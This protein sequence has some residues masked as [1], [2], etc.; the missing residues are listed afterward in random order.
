[1]AKIID[2][3]GHSGQFCVF[4][5]PRVSSNDFFLFD[6]QHD[7]S[8]LSPIY[9]KMYGTSAARS[10]GITGTNAM[11]QRSNTSL[12]NGRYQIG[13]LMKPWTEFKQYTS[14][15]SNYLNQATRKFDIS[16]DRNNPAK[17]GAFVINNGSND[18]VF[19]SSGNNTTQ[20]YFYID[21]Y[22]ISSDQ[23]FNDIPFQGGVTT[24]TIT[25]SPFNSRAYSFILDY[26]QPTSR[27]IWSR[28]NY[29]NNTSSW[30]R[31]GFG[32]IPVSWPTANTPQA[33]FILT[34][35]SEFSYLGFSE[36]DGLPH[37]LMDD[38]SGSRS[39]DIQK[40]T[41]SSLNT[42]TI[43]K[44]TGGIT[45]SNLAFQT[46]GADLEGLA[47][48]GTMVGDVNGRMYGSSTYQTRNR[49]TKYFTDPRDVSGNTV[50]WY[51]NYVDEESN[52]H[53]ILWTWD[54]SD[55]TFKF[56]TDTQMNPHAG[57]TVGFTGK[58]SEV[59]AWNQTNLF[60]GAYTTYMFSASTSEQS[61][62]GA[63]LLH[64]FEFGGERYL[65]YIW[66]D[67]ARAFTSSTLFRT[68]LTWKIDAADPRVF[69]F[70]SKHVLNVPF[71]EYIFLNDEESLMGLKD[72][73]SF[74][75]Y[76][77]NSATGWEQANSLPFDVGS[78]GRDSTDRIWFIKG[79]TSLGSTSYPEVHLL[80]PTLPLTVTVTP[81]QTSYTYAGS[82][83][84][85]TVDVSAYNAT[86]D[87]IS[88]DVK[89]LIEGTGMTFTGGVTV[90]TVT[91]SAVA[92]LAVD[93]FINSAGFSNITASV[94]V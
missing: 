69:T 82:Q 91:T 27:L 37:W 23:G 20:A 35:Y 67:E 36:V 71:Q 38:W 65:T 51:T 11:N 54:K 68:M 17:A 39:V 48:D 76:A 66:V 74:Q 19:H 62:T 70:H 79:S 72:Y 73:Y 80:T 57:A 13:S 77:F 8:T 4:E 55:D 53:P 45:N 21:S 93:I 86:G 88:T 24:N 15:S 49:P 50:L 81:A 30:Y 89:L 52:F 83:I 7:F 94:D 40:C 41:S 64:M 46:G 92:E 32:L 47:S 44:T 2:Y 25:S 87:R 31:Y 75:I 56:Q 42:S 18:A 16:M 33:G 6:A 34:A 14:V 10:N 28:M 84:P 29:E 12:T 5:D 22:K 90:L 43:V 78:M 58:S 9:N 85:S 1:M 26:Y 63:T 3:Q 59:D 61:I 60:E